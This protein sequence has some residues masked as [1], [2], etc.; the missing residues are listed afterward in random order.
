MQ[1][2]R[3]SEATLA[4]VQVDPQAGRGIGQV[5]GQPW[6]HPCDTNF[7]VMQNAKIIKSTQFA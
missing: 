7:A 5:S 4:A 6:H 3:H 2:A 1:L